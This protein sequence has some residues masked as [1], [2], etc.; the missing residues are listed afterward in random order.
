MACGTGKTFVCLWVKEQLKAKRTLVL[1][2]SLNLLSQMLNEWT[3]AARE[4]FDALCVCSDQTANR[5]DDDEAISLAADFPFPVSQG[6]SYFFNLPVVVA[7]R[8]GTETS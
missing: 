6:S 8:S 4:P 3:F 5:R 7:G 2:P 1:V